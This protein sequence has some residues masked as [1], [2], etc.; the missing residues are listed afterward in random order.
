MDFAVYLGEEKIIVFKRGLGIVLNEPA[1]VARGG[2]KVLAVGTEALRY[3]DNEGVTLGAPVLNGRVHFVED[4]VAMLK[5]ASKR[6]GGIVECV[7]C[8][9][10]ALSR[11]EMDDYKTAIYSAGINEA[12]FVPAVLANAFDHGYDLK[13]ADKYIST[14]ICGDFADMVVI[15]KGE[16]I[17]GGVVDKIDSVE[18]ARRKLLKKYPEMKEYLG[19]RINVIKG[20][21]SMIGN[22]ALIKKI[23]NIN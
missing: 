5:F 1:L 21:G 8:V 2:D 16:I 11:E 10:S 9:P 17:D 14:V 23:L 13:F 15:Y 19:D 3:L 20:A 18:F 12:H 22:P 7:F 6:V 4:A